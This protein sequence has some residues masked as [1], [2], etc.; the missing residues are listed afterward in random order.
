MRIITASELKQNL[1]K[2][3]DLS[4]EEDIIV[5]KNGKVVTMLTS[6]TLREDAL[7]AFLA[8]SGKYQYVD[9]ES[10]LDERD[11]KR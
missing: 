1:G 5:K 10:I 2:Y 8:L 4:K 7:A 3:I 9:Y 6:P 11:G